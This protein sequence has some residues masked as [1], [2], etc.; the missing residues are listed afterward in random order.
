ML[1]LFRVLAAFFWLPWISTLVAATTRP[2]IVIIL[3]DD[4]GINDLGSY[5]RADHRTPH[6]DQL[7]RE[8]VRF[9]SAYCAQP[10]CSPSRAALLTGNTPAQLHLTT[11]LPGRANASSQK[12]LQ[13]P[14]KKEIPL[15]EKMLS[16]YFTEAGYV[17]AAIGKWHVGGPGYGPEEHG[18]TI[19]KNAPVNTTPSASEGSK[20]EFA[21]TRAAEDFIE[22]NR[23]RPFLLY[24]GHN[25]PHIPYK[26]TE[27][28]IASHASAFEPTYAAVIETLD[29][30]VGQL[31]AKLDSL[32][33]ANN[34]LVIFTSDNGGLHVPEGPHARV[35]H[36]TPYRAGKGYLYE[37]GLRIPLVVRW[38]QHIPSNRVVDDPVINTDWIATLLDLSGIPG[39]VPEGGHSFAPLLTGKDVSANQ[40][41]SFFWHYPHY[42]N[43][44]GR[45]AGAVRRGNWKLVEYYDAPDQPELYELTT[46]IGEKNNVASKFPERVRE[47]RGDLDHWRRAIDAQTT[48][49]NPDFDPVKFRELYVDFDPSLFDPLRASKQEWSDV[50]T[51]RARM[52]AAVFPST[53]RQK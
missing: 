13:P 14:I 40:N 21:L 1:T 46:D 41:R 25:N 12:R 24:L 47:L 31:L 36:N 17:T 23:E 6:L 20:G 43:Q 30:A 51:W 45:P 22:A 5:G 49:P 18:F 19:V 7:A 44:G 9:T 35:T 33:L 11:Y 32:Q 15:S 34:T 26:A 29:R 39:R 28:Q 8:G 50:A 53:N 42:N 48:E 2:N 10:I 16:R 52:N 27:D 38:P 3:C 37:G 4:L